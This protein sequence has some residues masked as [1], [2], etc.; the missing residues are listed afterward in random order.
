MSA[1]G[2][3]RDITNRV[4]SARTEWGETLAHAMTVTGNTLALTVAVMAVTVFLMVRRA[5]P[6]AAMVGFGALLG[7]LLMI[8]LKGLF[9]RSRP[10]VHDRLLDIDTYSFPSGHAMMSMIV[11]GLFAVAAYRLSEWVRA[12]PWILLIAPLWSIAIGCTRVY[13]GVHWMTDVVAGW[14]IGALWVAGCALL[15]ARVSP[16]H[17]VPI[18]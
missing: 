15:L 5:F 12:H 13:L 2:I 9:G 11:F 8:A 7:Y 16:R 17:A 18:E 10:P 6:E 3:D 1:V 4:V 14:L